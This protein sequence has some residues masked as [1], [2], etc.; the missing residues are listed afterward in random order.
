M[1]WGTTIKI[2]RI[3]SLSYARQIERFA[4]VAYLKKKLGK[5]W[6]F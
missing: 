4:C 1:V 6:L 5:E 2:Q 3:E